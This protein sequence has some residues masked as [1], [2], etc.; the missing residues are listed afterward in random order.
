VVNRWE[1]NSIRMNREKIMKIGKRVHL[2]F[3]FLDNHIINKLLNTEE[4]ISMYF[5]KYV[6]E[7]PNNHKYKKLI[8]DECDTILSEIDTNINKLT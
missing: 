8:F 4:K 6:N 3:D 7:Y 5:I 1:G 2:D